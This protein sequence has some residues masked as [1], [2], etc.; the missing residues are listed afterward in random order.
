[1]WTLMSTG[2]ITSTPILTEA[3]IRIRLPVD[4]VARGNG[5]ITLSTAKGYLTGTRIPVSN[6]VSQGQAL[7]IDKTTGDKLPVQQTDQVLTEEEETWQE[8]ILALLGPPQRTGGGEMCQAA[9][10]LEVVAGAHLMGWIEGGEILKWP[11]TEEAPADRA[12]L[13]LAA[14]EEAVVSLGVAA[15]VVAAAEEAAEVPVEV[16]VVAAAAAE[17]AAAEGR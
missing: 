11:V 9:E 17:E 15:A 12:C 3:N 4:R 13:H 10:M 5:S 2:I 14:A 16:V 1:M 8:G 7:R 6:T